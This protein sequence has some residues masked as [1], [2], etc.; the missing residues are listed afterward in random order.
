MYGCARGQPG[1]RAPAGLHRLAG[2]GPHDK[3]NHGRRLAGPHDKQPPRTPKRPPAR[4]TLHAQTGPPP[5]TSTT[6]SIVCQAYQKLAASAGGLAK[7]TEKEAGRRAAAT[8][9]PLP[10][11]IAE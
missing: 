5:S 1:R 6:T 11:C 3:G 4:L 7:L 8:A 10:A 9:V 2:V